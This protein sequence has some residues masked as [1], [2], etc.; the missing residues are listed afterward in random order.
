MKGQIVRSRMQWLKDGER[1][2]RYLSSLE[3]KNFI[4]KTIKKVTLEDGNI[5]TQQE[6]ILNHIQKYYSRL[7]E[8]KD[9][10][11]NIAALDH[12][13]L[14]Q[15]KNPPKKNIGTLLTTKEI[16]AVLKK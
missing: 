10:L 11:L 12:L 3:N 7:F 13:G 2:S 16:G 4:E 14:Q 1:A 6:E 5:V 8:N 15:P 9:H